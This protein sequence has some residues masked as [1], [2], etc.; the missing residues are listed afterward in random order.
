[1]IQLSGASRLAIV[2]GLVALGT[3]FIYWYNQPSTLRLLIPNIAPAEQRLFGG[4]GEVLRR[5]RAG[6]RLEIV[7]T[8][9]VAAGLEAFE[10]GTYPLAIMRLDAVPARS[11]QEI[12]IVRRE[13]VVIVVPANSSVTSMQDLEGRKL[14]VARNLPAN[15]ML[16]GTLLEQFSLGETVQ[17]VPLAYGDVAQAVR[18][19]KVAAVLLVGAPSQRIV[20]DAVADIARAGDGE[21][22]IL[23]VELTEAV[24]GRSARFETIEVRRGAFGGSTPRPSQNIT[25][26]QIAMRLMARPDVTTAQGSELLAAILSNR[27]RLSV[28]NPIAALIEAP[29]TESDTAVTV[30][31]GALAHL[32]GDSQGFFDR[33]SDALYLLLFFGSFL[34]S[35]FAGLMG[36][37]SGKSRDKAMERLEEIAD[38]MRRASGTTD[39]AEL[40]RIERQADDIVLFV[41]KGTAQR[42]IEQQDATALQIGLDA[43]RG[44]IRRAQRDVERSRAAPSLAVVE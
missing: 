27:Q 13:A 42:T 41:L 19:K 28:D 30:H 39:D 32:N 1:M 12:A 23:P 24:A 9:D 14:G 2:L 33:Y 3:L 17:L 31:R 40:V 5:D 25:T 8:E 37:L 43:L 20:Q 22:N 34:G 7:A 4:L 10:A 38:L 16:A 6:I 44:A 35:A 21:P 26:T 15:M 29:D 36:F 11:A 18:D